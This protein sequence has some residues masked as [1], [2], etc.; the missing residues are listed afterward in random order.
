EDTM[1]RALGDAETSGDDGDRAKGCDVRPQMNVEQSKQA[2]A[3]EPVANACCKAQQRG[4]PGNDVRLTGTGLRISDGGFD[5]SRDGPPQ[6]A[7]ERDAP[8]AKPFGLGKSYE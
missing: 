1:Q 8:C 2:G 5:R 4:E 3:A 6:R 7:G